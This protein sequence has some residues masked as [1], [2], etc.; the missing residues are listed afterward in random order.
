MTLDGVC[1][2]FLISYRWHQAAFLLGMTVITFVDFF[3]NGRLG[4]VLGDDRLVD[5]IWRSFHGFPVSIG[6]R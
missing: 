4:N 1:K 3:F 6:R 2:A 5:T